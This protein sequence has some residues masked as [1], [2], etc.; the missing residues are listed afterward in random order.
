MDDRSRKNIKEA[1]AQLSHATGI[2]RIDRGDCPMHALSPVACTFCSYGHML[3]C[4]YPKTCEET[5]CSH[6]QETIEEE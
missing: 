1:E 6:Y 4:H 5:E 2:G 3:D